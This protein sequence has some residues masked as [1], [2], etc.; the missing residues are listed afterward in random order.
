[1]VPELL[2]ACGRQGVRAAVIISSGFAEERGA[3]GA[4]RQA[5]VRDIAEHHGMVV[6]GPNAEG[7]LNALMPLA[8]TFSPAATE[9]EDHPA[10][11]PAS[12]CGNIGIVSQSGGVGFAFYDRGR[13]KGLGFSYV[14]STGNE[15]ALES[16]DVVEY[17][18]R[19]ARTDVVLMFLEGLRTPRRILG[20]AREAVRAGKPLIVAKMG[21]SEAGARAVVSHTSALAGSSRVYD[22]VFRHLGIV[23]G[24]DMD[25]MIDVAA[26]FAF[27]RDDLP[28]GKRVGVLTPSGGAGVWLA[29]QC[30]AHGLEVPELDDATRA[31]ID[32]LLP[33]YAS[34][35]NPLDV[36]AQGIFQLGYAR[37]LEMML[38][39]PG[40]DAVLV[41]SSLIHANYIERDAQSLRELRA[42]LEKPVIFC[43][44]TRAGEHAV[45]LLG[46]A[47]FP[48]LTSMPGC[49]QALAAMA[50]FRA[51]RE[52]ELGRVE[53]PPPRFAKAALAKLERARDTLCEHEAKDMLEA[54]GIAFTERLL[55]NTAEQ[56]EAAA[57]SFS[58][59]VAL[60]IQSP[61]ISHKSEAGGVM[62]DL[63]VHEVR[64]AFAALI[65]RAREYRADAD[66]HGVLVEP[67]AA[68]GV[69][70]LVGVH[71][72]PDFGPVLAVGSGGVLAEVLDDVV[73]AP[74]PLDRDQCLAMIERL[75]GRALLEGVRGR[76]PADVHALVD[77]L[78]RVSHLADL[79]PGR[80]VE[81]DLNPVVVHRQG[82]GLTV[83][84]AL[85]VCGD[86]VRPARPERID[87]RR[88]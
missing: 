55:A 61:Q 88:G 71:R 64:G 33:S 72:D 74:A 7:F 35:R 51:H 15:A 65:A 42:R 11:P 34:S 46:R 75:R 25:R 86:D 41:A 52:R 19:D 56:A 81:L 43:A 26:G 48:C 12:V 31:R 79:V 21:R 50:D 83:V 57:R 84:D 49:A 45:S 30:A 44:Y 5:A 2:E 67:M 1:M 23:P 85:V 28:R 37:P 58:G 78:H 14:V 29:D 36:T 68:P 60:K 63:E 54:C 40:I 53:Q 18:L 32:P 20:I 70:M 39:S 80:I 27:F 13:A 22:A 3:G 47:G 76:A 59:R 73:L 9:A 10:A 6:C 4:S 38:R 69:E 8:A 16:L 82:L 62:L 24:E 77:L 17:M 87:E 66:V